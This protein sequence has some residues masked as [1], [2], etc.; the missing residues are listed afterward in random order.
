MTITYPLTAP[1]DT[2]GISNITLRAR[3]AVG[4]NQSP[5]TYQQQVF[6]HPGQAWSADIQIAPVNRE[7]GEPWVAFLLALEGPTGTFL[8]GDPLGNKPRGSAAEGLTIVVDGATAADARFFAVRGLTVSTSGLF[9][10]G[11]YV[12]LGSGATATLHKILLAVDSDS[13]GEADVYVWPRPRRAL[14]DG[15]AVTHWNPKGRFRL[16][17]GEQAWEIANN[18]RYGVSFQA[19]EAIG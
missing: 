7:F 19:M 1:T 8:L 4:M 3:N 16:A 17:P 18:L 14:T 6:R 13:S 9:L 12:Q 5:F 10:P 15:E 2:I 11:D